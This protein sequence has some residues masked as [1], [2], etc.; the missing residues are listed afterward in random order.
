MF[1]RLD[2]LL[3]SAI[4]T[5]WLIPAAAKETIE[6]DVYRNGAIRCHSST[7]ATI[8]AVD[9]GIASSWSSSRPCRSPITVYFCIGD[10]GKIYEPRIDRSSGDDQYDAECLEAVCGLSPVAPERENYTAHLQQENVT[11]G[12][13]VSPFC[14]KPKYDGGEV[15]V[16]LSKHS[17]PAIRETWTFPTGFVIVHKIPLYVLNRYP[18]F[19]T[20]EELRNSS[21]LIEIPFMKEDWNANHLTVPYVSPVGSLYAYWGQL[22]KRKNVNKEDILNWAKGAERWAK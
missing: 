1:R 16:Y 7:N 10:D 6:T 11:F 21:N 5:T 18:G 2:V 15:K 22:F 20:E 3:A 19:F 14:P 17:Q 8:N 4:A 9:H 13:S 12:S